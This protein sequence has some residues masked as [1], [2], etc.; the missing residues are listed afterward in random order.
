MFF[1]Y[2]FHAYRFFALIRGWNYVSCIES[3][4]WGLQQDQGKSQCGKLTSVCRNVFATSK[5]DRFGGSTTF[6]LP[7]PSPSQATS[8][9]VWFATGSGLIASTVMLFALR[10]GFRKRHGH[11]KLN[12]EDDGNIQI[13][14][15]EHHI[16]D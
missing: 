11:T 5:L 9:A 15:M 13:T 7:D 14:S 8:M 6:S 10:G 3:V 12:Q 1:W 16:L 2:L 4:A